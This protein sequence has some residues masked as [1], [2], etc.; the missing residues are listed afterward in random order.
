[1]AL[2]LT[3]F[4][5]HGATGDARYRFLLW[6]ELAPLTG[7]GVCVFVMLNPSTADATADDPTIRRV[8]GFAGAWGFRSVQVVNLFALRATKPWDLCGADDPVGPGNDAHIERALKGADRVVAAWGSM[9]RF[10]PTMFA[11]RRDAVAERL[12]DRPIFCLG[13][14]SVD[15]QP[16]HPLYV[17]KNTALV[18]YPP[19][20]ETP[21]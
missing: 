21:P 10:K 13:Y 18:P 12:A 2:G 20:K 11:T 14:T 9:T 1:M 15:Q 19:P 8:V 7:E 3:H 5:G 17:P 16:R 4:D 6:R